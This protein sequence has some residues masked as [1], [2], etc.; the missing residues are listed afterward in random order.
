MFYYLLNN[1]SSFLSIST[2]FRDVIFY[3][4]LPCWNSDLLLPVSIIPTSLNAFQSVHFPLFSI[5]MPLQLPYPIPNSL[6]L[7]FLLT[8][9]YLF[10]SPVPVF[11][12]ASPTLLPGRSPHAEPGIGKPYLAAPILKFCGPGKIWDSLPCLTCVVE[13][14]AGRLQ[15]GQLRP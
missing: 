3:P 12:A 10:S 2:Q 6:L 1:W 15:L 13:A 8:W 9:P 11:V 7:E 14:G 4:Y 5:R